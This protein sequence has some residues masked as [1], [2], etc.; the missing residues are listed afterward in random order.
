MSTPNFFIIGAP[1]AGTTALAHYLSEHEKVFFSLVKEPFFWCD[2]FNRNGHEYKCHSI[3]K[4]LDLFNEATEDI[5]AIGEGSTRYL[6][7]KNAVKNILKFNPKARFIIMLRNPIESVPAFHMEQMYSLEENVEDFERA[8][9]LQD[10]RKSGLY[11]PP[12]CNNPEF[13]QYGD[14]YKYAEQLE[15]VYSN[16]SPD[17]VKV[18][19]FDDFKTDTLNVYKDT[20]SFLGLDYDGREDFPIL[21]SAHK[22]RSKFIANIILSPPKVLEPAMINFRLWLIKKR[23]PIVEAIKRALNVKTPRAKISGELEFELKEYFKDDVAKLSKILNQDLTYW[24][25]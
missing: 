6:R 18:I 8:W 17:K 2:D 13:L 25:K 19:I 14:V 10:K 21:N 1:K 16:V 12:K 20:L 22:H 3:E 9:K 4:Y 24:C 23:L 5:I 15:H 7:S 11:L